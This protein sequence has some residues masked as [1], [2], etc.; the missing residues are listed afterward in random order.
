MFPGQGSQYPGMGKD[1]LDRFPKYIDNA[2]EILGLSLKDLLFDKDRLSSTRF[3]QPAI[4]LVSSLSYLQYEETP[5]SLLLGH[6]LGLAAALF[7]AEVYD[8]ETGFKIVVE[9]GRLM[10]TQDGGSMLAVLGDDLSV[11]EKILQ[12]IE[13]FEVDIANYNSPNQIVLSGTNYG[14]ETCSYELSNRGYRCVEL[15]V[16]GAFH[17]RYMEAVQCDFFN[18]LRSIKLNDPKKTVISTINGEA[19]HKDFILEELCYQLT[20]PVRWSQTIASLVDKHTDLD[21]VEVAPG[22]TLSKLN[23]Q[24]MNNG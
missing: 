17:S 2:S 4:Y 10:S 1:L 21:F 3:T 16:S 5:G 7:A 11:I 19:I 15:A 20:K 18:F 14:I 23:K 12:D 6:S 13:C 24:I 8:F 9:R 22:N